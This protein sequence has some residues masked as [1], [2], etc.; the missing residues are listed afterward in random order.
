MIAVTTHAVIT[1]SYHRRVSQKGNL[2]YL[3]CRDLTLEIVTLISGKVDRR[4]ASI[5]AME[6]LL[7]SYIYPE[8]R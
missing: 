3:R 7:V 2:A 1:S 4:M 5:V 6:S 8:S